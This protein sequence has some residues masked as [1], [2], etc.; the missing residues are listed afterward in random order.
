MNG[1]NSTLKPGDKPL[2]RS[3]PLKSGDK[4]L[5]AAVIRQLRPGEVVPDFRPRRYTSSDHGYVRLRW[6]VGV[7]Q[8][9][10]TYEHRVVGGVVTT[11]EQVHH[12]NRNKKDN[13]ASNLAHLTAD[14]HR[15]EH[16]AELQ[17][18]WDRIVTLHLT[19]LNTSQVAQIVR[20]D[21]S[22]VWRVLN[23][24]GIKVRQPVERE[25]DS[26]DAVRLYLGGAG[27]KLIAKVYGIDVNRVRAAIYQAG[28]PRRKVG[29]QRDVT[30]FEE[31]RA[32]HLVRVR[33]EGICERCYA[34]PAQHWHHRMNKSQGGRWRPANGGHLCPPCH[35]FVTDNPVAAHDE[36]WTV[37]SW[38]DPA[39]V[40]VDIHG[41][42]WLLTNAGGWTL[43]IPKGHAA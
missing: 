38:E 13:S 23:R 41:R 30:T 28:A 27:I 39:L 31:A 24:C 2:Q 10:E 1:W 29:R 17:P 14:E 32:R 3:A 12:R 22:N 34:A 20:R 36:G 43:Y 26:E 40:P 15:A 16:H 4:P 6:K 35:L 11:A 42:S 7:R 18:D 33:S 25:I 8:Y 9:V 5:R 19:G 37:W 21:E